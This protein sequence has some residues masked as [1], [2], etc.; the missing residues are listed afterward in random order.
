M[1]IKLLPVVA[2]IMVT[3][4]MLVSCLGGTTS[5]DYDPET[6]I[7]AFSIGSLP[8]DVIGL[9]SLGNDSAYV[10]SVDGSEYP[11]TINQ[12]TRTI[13][14]KDSLPLNTRVDKVVCSIS[15]DAGYVFYGKKYSEDDDGTDT[16]WTSTDS[17]NFEYGPLE[18]KV[19]SMAGVWGLPYTVKVNV[20]QENPDSMMWTDH[21]DRSFVNGKIVRQKALYAD[22]RIV[23][24]GKNASGESVLEYT[25]LTYT[26]D[27]EVASRASM[28]SWKQAEVPE[29]TEPYSAVVWLDE[30]WFI[31]G[32]GTLYSM[33]PS[34]L[35]YEVA[36]LSDT[37]SDLSF[38]LAGAE[39]AS[40]AYLY[41]RSSTGNFYVYDINSGAWKDDGTPDV[42][43]ELDDDLRAVCT[44]IPSSYNSNLVNVY[45]I[46]ENPVE[47]DSCA[48]IGKRLTSDNSWIALTAREDTM[49]CPN[50]IDPTMFYYNKQLYAFGGASLNNTS[51][52]TDSVFQAFDAIFVS[53]NS[54]LSWTVS[55]LNATFPK[56]NETFVS[57]YDQDENG[58]YSSA[59]DEQ[60]FI[61]IIWT[62]GA[63]H[64]GRINHLG[65]QSKW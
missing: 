59:L 60:N 65:Y 43:Y 14:N 4:S 44:V 49:S 58:G 31:A 29:E 24:F 16:I 61:W 51:L 36:S 47:S 46:S 6:S 32:E 45:T 56:D 7:T 26:M 42:N 15:Y 8:I 27:G 21:T 33:D 2:A 52:E 39:T 28:S 18:F 17:I 11:F 10:D 64:R 5:Y 25:D 9:D 57:H 1:K 22:N 12:L 55:S 19:W 53:K 23:V 35:E 37:P 50:I 13:E 34:T 30:I 3:V 48:I 63:A 54:G 62:D 20:H 40:N 38:L 41:G